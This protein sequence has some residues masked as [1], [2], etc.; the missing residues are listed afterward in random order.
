MTAVKA[1]RH[2]VESR[3]GLLVGFFGAVVEVNGPARPQRPQGAEAM[4]AE[5]DFRALLAES[6]S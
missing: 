5:V 4:S 3:I 2:I 6:A 1:K